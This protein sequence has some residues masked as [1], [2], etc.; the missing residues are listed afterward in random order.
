[1]THHSET[2]LK[3]DQK[4]PMT[5]EETLLDSLEWMFVGVCVNR[6]QYSSC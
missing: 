6:V 4:L 2:S 5:R 3:T 1:M